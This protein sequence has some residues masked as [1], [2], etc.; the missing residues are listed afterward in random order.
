MG[1]V[2]PCYYEHDLKTR[3]TWICSNGAVTSYP[4]VH[5]SYPNIQT[6][7]PA[8]EQVKALLGP[9]SKGCQFLKPTLLRLF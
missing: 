3:V 8:M 4:M 6:S 5:L 7:N 9:Q 2:L 1:K